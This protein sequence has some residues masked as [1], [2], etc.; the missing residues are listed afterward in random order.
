MRNTGTH[1]QIRTEG[2]P[3]RRVHR[4]TAA[5]GSAARSDLTSAD[6]KPGRAR[7]SSARPARR[8]DRAPPQHLALLFAYVRKGPVVSSQIEGTQCSLADL[9]LY[10]RHQASQPRTRAK[11]RTTSPRSTTDSRGCVAAS[12]FRSAS[13]A[14]PKASCSAVGRSRQ[15]AW[16]AQTQLGLDR[17]LAP[18]Q[19]ALRP[20]ACGPRC[21]V[22]GRAGEVPAR[23][24][25]DDPHQGLPRARAVRDH[26]PVPRR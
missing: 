6:D 9:L 4:C 14:R 10:E 5:S 22:H 15:I 7:Q 1:V 23:R 16:R 21:R 26:P 19:R 20:T 8:P 2:E 11:S 13:S 3:F 25:A 24:G 12:R 17:W 18:G